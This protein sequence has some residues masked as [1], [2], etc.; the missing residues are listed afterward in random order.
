MSSKSCTVYPDVA[1]QQLGLDSNSYLAVL[2]HDPKIDDPALLT[3]LPPRRPMSAY[4]AARAR[5]NNACSG[6]MPPA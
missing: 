1:L 3:A 2:T 5:T 6:Y 4:S